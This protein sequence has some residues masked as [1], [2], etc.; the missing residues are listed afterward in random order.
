M[1]TDK[2][3]NM[4][5]EPQISI[6]GIPLSEGQGMAVRVACEAFLSQMREE[7]L[8]DD[9]HGKLMAELYAERLLEVRGLILLR[10]KP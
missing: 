5:N 6:N 2:G 4:K 9:E 7:G 3:R 1:E 8:G 10:A